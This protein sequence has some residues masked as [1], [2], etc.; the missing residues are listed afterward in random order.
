MKVTTNVPLNSQ[1]EKNG[2]ETLTPPLQT[3]HFSRDQQP[4]DGN[5]YKY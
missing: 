1:A 2:V 4:D 5:T 3:E